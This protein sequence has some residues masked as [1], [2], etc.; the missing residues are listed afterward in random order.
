MAVALVQNSLYMGGFIALIALLL[1]VSYLARDSASSK[2]ADNDEEDDTADNAVTAVKFSRFQK[3]YLVVYSLVI[4][5]DW[6]QGPYVYQLYKDYGYG[7]ADISLLF[8]AGFLSSAVLGTLAGS[9]SDKVGRKFMCMVFCGVYALSCLT[10]LSPKFPILI[11]G[12]ITGGIATSLLFSVFEAWM[13]SEHFSRGFKDSLLSETF[14]WATFLNG[15]VAILSGVLANFLVDIW[16]P[17]AP[18]M[19]AIVFLVAASFI[20]STTWVENYGNESAS[21]SKPAF[22]A[23]VEGIALVR[24]D[25]KILAAGSMQ[26]FFESTMYTFVFL[27]PP[28]LGGTIDST[29]E[30][31]PFGIIFAALMVSIMIGSVFFRMAMKQKIS[32]EDV[33]K[34]VFLV[35]AI[36][37]LI[38]AL[39]IKSP[40]M[41]FLGFNL[42]EWCCGLY[43]PA[44]GTI[45]SKVIPEEIRA[46]VMN[47]FR[48]PLNLIVV[49]TLLRVDEMDQKVLFILC[50]ISVA[51]AGIFASNLSDQMKISPGEGRERV[52]AK[53]DEA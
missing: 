33:I 9:I 29:V 24:S 48:I 45:R 27:W 39:N 14:G 43:F 19:A 3:N 20:I 37:F 4:I 18:F 15:F 16:G 6:L 10:K 26:T 30:S 7:L 2:S 40:P 8:V 52:G 22:A 46:T 34:W 23:L 1:V 38:P 28:V 21:T 41:V 51:V 42:F 36:S 13:V 47:L 49:I 44:M 11:F 53:D 32:H 35:A 5:S 50:S 31:L 25:F 12:R 17:V